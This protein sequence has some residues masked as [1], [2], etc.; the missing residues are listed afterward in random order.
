MPWITLLEAAELAGGG[1]RLVKALVAGDVKGRMVREDWTVESIPAR[2]WIKAE[3]N[4][5]NCTIRYL[6]GGIY[7]FS[8]TGPDIVIDSSLSSPVKVEIDRQT[9]LDHFRSAAVAA[10][11]NVGGRPP[12]WDWEKF[13]LELCARIHED[14]LP[15]T[16]AEMVE[17]MG[18]WFVNDLGDHPA[19]SEIKKRVSGLW[20]RVGRG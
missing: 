12:K 7:T 18:Q 6:L 16:Q 13:W 2:R 15:A 4:W 8:Q 9:L 17:R 11:R 3:I 10:T 1:D 20:H 19:E 5:A 14:G